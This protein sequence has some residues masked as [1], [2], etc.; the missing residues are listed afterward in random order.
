MES[1]PLHGRTVVPF[2]TSGIN[3]T[4]QECDTAS[5]G[6]SLLWH[7]QVIKASSVNVPVYLS[8]KDNQ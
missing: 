5:A 4:A 1:N 8:P 2:Y 6:C 7:A 3:R